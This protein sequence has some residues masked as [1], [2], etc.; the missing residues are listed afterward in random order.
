MF[1]ANMTGIIVLLGF[2]V[3]GAPHLSMARSFASLGAFLMGAAIGG[4][5][6][7]SLAQ[8]ARARWLLVTGTAEA[9]LLF[10]AAA[11]HSHR[12]D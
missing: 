3:A 5:V 12:Q 1:T 11:P 9:G 8:P 4:R 7:A 2:A 10:G 6:G